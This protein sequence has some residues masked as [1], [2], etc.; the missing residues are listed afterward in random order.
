MVERIRVGAAR[1]VGV[2]RPHAHLVDAAVTLAHLE[3]FAKA[4]GARLGL[5]V[6]AVQTRSYEQLVQTLD[7]GE[8]ELGWLPP[9]VALRA[10]S[11]GLATPV[12]APLRG[13]SATFHAALFAKRGSKLKTDQHLAGARVAWVDR[14]SAAGYAVVR[15]ALRARGHD[16]ARMFS[17]ETFEGSHQA[18]VRAVL[19]GTADVG[20]TY[21]HRDSRGALVNPGWGD[22]DVELVFEHGPVP[23]DVL[24]ASLDLEPELVERIRSVLL[25]ESDRE[26]APAARELFEAEGFVRVSDDHFAPLAALVHHFDDP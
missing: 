16:P 14:A 12:V 15:A 26:L 5:G 4:L 2:T 22:A 1:T 24:A 18:V 6:E 23:S 25:D 17:V 13:G 11:I 9:V 19:D 10:V 8:L 21:V 20:A 7:A 3:R